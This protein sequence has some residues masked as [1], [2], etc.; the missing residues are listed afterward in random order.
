VPPQT[1][2]NSIVWNPGPD[3]RRYREKSSTRA[4]IIYT[5][6]IDVAFMCD[7]TASVENPVGL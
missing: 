2:K 1:T 3:S 6:W 4:M 7:N 5:P